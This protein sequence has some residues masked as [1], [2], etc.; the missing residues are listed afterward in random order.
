[1]DFD[2]VLYVIGIMVVISIGGVG[3]YVGFCDASLLQFL[4]KKMHLPCSI[5]VH[6]IRGLE[7]NDNYV[8]NYDFSKYDNSRFNVDINASGNIIAYHGRY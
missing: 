2:D 6:R 5:R 4:F 3:F 7:K 1:M 8:Y